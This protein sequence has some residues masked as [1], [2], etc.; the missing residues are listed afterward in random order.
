MLKLYLISFLNMYLGVG[1]KLHYKSHWYEL[2]IQDHAND[3]VAIQ[4]TVRTFPWQLNENNPVEHSIGCIKWLLETPGVWQTYQLEAAQK[5][6]IDVLLEKLVSDPHN[7]VGIK[8]AN[9]ATK[10][11]VLNRLMKEDFSG[12][13]QRCREELEIRK[14][15]GTEVDADLV[16]EGVE[17]VKGIFKL[18]QFWP[19]Y[20][21]KMIKRL[22]DEEPN[23][24]FLDFFFEVLLTDYFNLFGL[25][26]ASDNTKME[27]C[28][29]LY[30]D[31][32]FIKQVTTSIDNL[33]FKKKK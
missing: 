2:S 20:D 3:T 30:N 27:I 15:R 24:K 10:V 16:E 23:G 9:N 14:A 11:D 12:F 33:K 22:H 6:S 18:M 7:L 29:K 28:Q 13:K 19:E 17:K 25:R 1:I 21:K 26:D 32:N 4:N 31:Q 5:T 8:H